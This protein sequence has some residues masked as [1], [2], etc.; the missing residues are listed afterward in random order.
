M[1][2][3]KTLVNVFN[4]EYI[5]DKCGEGNM[6]CIETLATWPPQFKHRCTKCKSTQIF[7]VSYPRMAYD[8]VALEG[9]KDD[10]ET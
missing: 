1:S 7:N 2:V 6:V 4:E 8:R 5:C 9:K 3:K 10:K